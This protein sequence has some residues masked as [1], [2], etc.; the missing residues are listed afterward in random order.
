MDTTEQHIIEYLSRPDYAPVKPTKLAARLHLPKNLV[1]QYAAAVDRLIASGRVR[2]GRKGKLHLASSTGLIAGILK[3]I[4]SGAAFVIPHEALPQLGQKDI[5]ISA[6]DA[7][8]AHTGDEVLVSL[9]KRR[10][11]GGKRTGRV[12]EVVERATRSFVGVYLE[13]DGQSLV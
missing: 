13:R 10:G 7:R 9:L 2:E 12:E 4:S 6:A 11:M 5:F 1:P 8:D 3:R